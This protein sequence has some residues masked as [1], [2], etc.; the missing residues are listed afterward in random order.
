MGGGGF[1]KKQGIFNLLVHQI[2]NYLKIPG[3][4]QYMS[5]VR[6]L[7]PMNMMNHEFPLKYMY[8]I[9]MI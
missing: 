2:E 6:T 7:E 4:Y 9:G 5:N 8:Y 1:K 3:L